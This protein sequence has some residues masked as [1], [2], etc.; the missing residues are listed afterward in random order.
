MDYTLDKTI[1]LSHL[2][3]VDI[4]LEGLEATIIDTIYNSSITITDE[5]LISEI[6]RVFKISVQHSKMRKTVK[7]MIDENKIYYK[8][9]NINICPD[10]IGV[11]SEMIEKNQQ[12]E[13]NSLNDWTNNFEKLTDSTLTDFV[14]SSIKEAILKYIRTFFLYHGADSF[15]LISN[16]SKTI[17]F[18]IRNLTNECVKGIPEEYKECLK[19]F[20]QGLF[21]DA[22][23]EN[24]KQFCI[25][26]INKAVSYLSTVA[27]DE[28]KQTIINQIKGLTIY[29]DTPILYRL[30]NLQGEHRYNTIKTVIQ[31]CTSNNISLKIF[32]TTYNELKRRISYD[33]KLIEENPTPVDFATIG[34]N[35]RT[36]DNYIST[37]WKARKETG[38]SPKDFNFMYSDLKALILS[39]NIE[40]DTKDY[41]LE[42]NLENNKE[43]FTEK[44]SLFSNN[45]EEYQKSVNSIEHDA[46]CLTCVEYLQDKNASSAINSKVVFLSS[47]WSLIRLQRY[48]IDYKN[49]I[50]LVLLPSQL[51][52]LFFITQSTESFYDAF[53]TL[54]SSSRTS[55]GSKSL[56]N[57]Q[58]QQ[59][60][61]RIAM[62]KGA[63]ASFAERVLSNQLIETT[64][65]SIEKGE[66]KFQLIDDVILSEVEVLEGELN[67]HRKET[68][69]IKDD[70]IKKSNEIENLN[71]RL[72]DLEAKTKTARHTINN[73]VEK[74]KSISKYEQYYKKKASTESKIK[75][76]AR[77]ILGYACISFGICCA[78][79]AVCSIIPPLSQLAVP[80]LNWMASSVAIRDEVMTNEMLIGIMIAVAGILIPGGFKLVK[81]GYNKLQEN[82]YNRSLEKVI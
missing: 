20:L 14:S 32:Q 73:N 51:M 25:R 58:I 36:S 10:L 77:L 6:E 2:L 52:Q 4:G 5:N 3:A 13:E 16:N 71:Q 26:Q 17:N 56:S 61:G 40:I 31:Y 37:F 79:I 63:T 44:V 80:C 49:K 35:C 64:F 21:S 19:E 50:D 27:D 42:M 38:I 62:Y 75:T 9:N 45:D 70:S 65:S 41:V 15:S 82:Y 72:C 69:D 54:F 39:N 60:L 18:D 55:F 7:K 11:V 33:A 53:L 23:T 29:L 57:S 68:Q 12:L 46:V 1:Q 47:D 48:D 59:I 66:E 8:G 28:I 43:S 30:L 24:Q 76:L 34:Y 74:I 78:I 81:P 22:L 67:L